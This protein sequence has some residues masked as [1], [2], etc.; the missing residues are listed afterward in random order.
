[1]IVVDPKTRTFTE[2]P[3]KTA[4]ELQLRGTHFIAHNHPKWVYWYARDV[5]GKPWPA[6]EAAIAKDP[7][8]AYV[9]ALNVIKKPWT[10]GEAAIAKDPEWAYYYARNVIGKPWSGPHKQQ[11][12][13][14]IAGDP[15]WAYAYA[16]NLNLV[17]D[18]TNKRFT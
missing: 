8:W 13:A 4:F 6:G 5:I 7:K 17:Y 14:T 10:E 16:N 1:M 15:Y 2:V 3:E 12:E 9:Y 11:A 18:E